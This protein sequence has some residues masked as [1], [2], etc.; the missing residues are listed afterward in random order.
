[1][2]QHNRLDQ[3]V[4]LLGVLQVELSSLL[5]EILQSFQINFRTRRLCYLY[6]MVDRH[7]CVGPLLEAFDL[8]VEL[9]S[10]I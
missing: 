1:M 6:L 7:L 9:R 8:V 5:E 4:Q 3:L 2:L 10:D